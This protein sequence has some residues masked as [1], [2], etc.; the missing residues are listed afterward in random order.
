MTATHL[1]RTAGATRIARQL[2][3]ASGCAAVLAGC[4][5]RVE[6]MV[7]NAC[8]VALDVVV[9][10]TVAED[11]AS[12]PEGFTVRSARVPAGD[13]VKVG[14][15][16]DLANRTLFVEE[17]GYRLVFDDEDLDATES[18]LVIPADAC[19]AG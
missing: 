1:T 6:V 11:V 19:P 15:F 4:S 8:A 9:V 12:I 7:A 17:L 16:I 2:A 13:V 18:T 10:G 5:G 3:A 14:D